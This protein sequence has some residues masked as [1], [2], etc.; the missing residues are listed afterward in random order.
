MKQ[1]LFGTDGIRGEANLWPIVPD[2][3][4][5][6]AQT[7]GRYFTHSRAKGH[8]PTVVIG[9]DTRLSGYM[10]ETALTAG[11]VSVGMDVRLLG[12]LPT[13]AVALLTK[14]L[15]ADLGV[16]ISASHNPSCDN[17]IKFFTSDGF[18][19]S[20]SQ[21]NEILSL[22]N[23][24]ITLASG[25]EVGKAR[26]IDDA[27]GRYI[28][29]AKNS[30]PKGITLEGLK[31]VIDCAHGAAYKVAPSILWEL[32]ADIIKIGCDPNGIN[33]NEGCG[34]TD[35]TAIKKAVSEHRAHIGI[36]LDGDADRVILIDENGRIVD[37]DQVLAL[38]AT[39][40][41]ELALLQGRAVVAT[42]MSNLGLERY[43]NT[44]NLELI[45]TQVGDRYVIK[46][47]KQKGCNVGG[48]QSGHIILSDYTTTGDGLIAALQ[49]LAVLIRTQKSLG[50]LGCL[51]EPVPQLLKNIK[52]T[53]TQAFK[54]NHFQ[55]IIEAMERKLFPHGRLVVRPSGTEPILRIM[56]QGDDAQQLADCVEEI[57]Q[58]LK[59]SAL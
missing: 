41:H 37:G 22:L 8:R 9:K 31:I 17:G 4:L 40:F 2:V 13:P 50:Q 1:R 33:I 21:Q 54:N 7:T 5:R 6:V 32:G 26:R 57:S 24:D 20:D 34:A 11:F 29:V 30:F 39:H 44:L 25:L 14:S 59:V 23:H 56:A 48:E 27:I 45:R 28:E 55:Q 53:S 42:F 19:L 12:P 38:I 15:R 58:T 52:I 46:T 10:I 3:I 47:M 49:V 18:K 36:T 35:L 43:L 51:F 16:M